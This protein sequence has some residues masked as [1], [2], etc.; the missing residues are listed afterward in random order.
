[1]N[2]PIS[3]PPEKLSLFDRLFNR[4]KTVVAD[5]GSDMWRTCGP[6]PP[7]EE[8]DIYTRDWVEYHVIDHATGSV[9]IIQE[10]LN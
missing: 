3:Y 5:R 6:Y 7:Y 9:E 4:Y 1:M 10:Y 2:E 8:F